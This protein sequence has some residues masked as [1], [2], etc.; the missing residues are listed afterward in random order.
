MAKE[1]HLY[2]FLGEGTVFEGTIMVPHDI[3]IDGHF[4][5][6]LDTQQE[7]HIGENAV[8]EAQISARSAFIAGKVVGN[9]TA[10]E[11]VELDRNAV[12]KGDLKTR[13]LVIN[14]GATFQGNCAMSAAEK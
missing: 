14:E 2:S 12:L 1:N 6:K 11:R 5:G 10:A 4:K 3:R 8:V 13:D 7:L 9:I